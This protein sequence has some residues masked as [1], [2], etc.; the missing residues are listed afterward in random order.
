M[1]LLLLTQTPHFFSFSG[2]SGLQQL[3]VGSQFS[4]QRLNWAA[5][6]KVP[7]PNH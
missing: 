1:L 3:D 4:D 2:H 6:V 7:N 5:V